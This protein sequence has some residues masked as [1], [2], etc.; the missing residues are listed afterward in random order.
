MNRRYSRFCLVL[1]ICISIAVVAGAQETAFDPSVL[2]THNVSIK[3]SD[4]KRVNKAGDIRVIDQRFDRS[5]LG[6]I[7]AYS[8][9]KLITKDSLAQTIERALNGTTRKLKQTDSGTGWVVVI[10]HLW[11]DGDH[12]TKAFRSSARIAFDCYEKNEDSYIPRFQFDTLITSAKR[13]DLC[14]ATLI[15]DAFAE[16]ANRMNEGLDHFVGNRLTAAEL[17]LRYRKPL[18]QAFFTDTTPVDG[19]YLSYKDILQK[20][21]AYTNFR[22]VHQ[23]LS[24]EIYVND[25]GKEMMLSKTWGYVING[26]YYIRLHHSFFPMVRQQNGF[27]LLGYEMLDYVFP[28]PKRPVRTPVDLVGAALSNLDEK[29]SRDKFDLKPMQ[30][31]METGRPYSAD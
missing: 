27:D 3:S 24:D 26:Q 11:L 29:L 25:N 9:V 4:F 12:P 18:Q 13:L 7:K 28:Q 10:R 19:V 31:N 20:K 22:L 5:K 2:K 30:L 17:E 23:E 1:L 21:P 6:Y 16:C 8:S 14:A 15:A